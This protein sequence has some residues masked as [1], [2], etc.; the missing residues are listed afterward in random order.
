MKRKFDHPAPSE[1]EQLTGP[2]YWRSL[3]ELTG[4]PGFKAQVERGGYVA[5]VGEPQGAQAGV[6]VDTLLDVDQCRVALVERHR[7]VQ[8][9]NRE[10]DV[11]E[12]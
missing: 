4:T 3:D 10:G 7:R 8:I 5:L 1:R 2:K 11:G 9:T 6:R 12:Q